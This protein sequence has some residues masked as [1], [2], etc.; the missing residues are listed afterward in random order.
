MI[1]L[2]FLL[3]EPIWNQD[4]FLYF[5][6]VKQNLYQWALLFNWFLT[7]ILYPTNTPNPNPAIDIAPDV[8]VW[9]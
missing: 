4:Y 6:F 3:T 2:M 5:T 8:N 7:M 1:E 9:I